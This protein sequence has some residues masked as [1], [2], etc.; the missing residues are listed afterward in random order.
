MTSAA[1]AIAHTECADLHRRI[2]ALE[3]TIAAGVA[4][5]SRLNA[6]IVARDNEIDALNRQIAKLQAELDAIRAGLLE[7]P[8]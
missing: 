1:E 3:K 5:K 2:D 4:C 7:L 6:L 8:Y